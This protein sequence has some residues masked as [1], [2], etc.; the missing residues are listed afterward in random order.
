MLT[1]EEKQKVGLFLYRI[2][3]LRVH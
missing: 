1:C 2:E 3:G